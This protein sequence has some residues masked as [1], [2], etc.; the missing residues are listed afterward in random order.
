MPARSIRSFATALAAL[1]LQATANAVCIPFQ[2]AAQHI[3][4]TGCVTGKVVAISQG[5]EGAQ[6]VDFCPAHAGCGF[7]A[8]VYADDLRDVGDIRRLP[9]KT[10]EL[11]GRIRADA[12][13]PQMVLSDARQLK[14]ASP[15]LPPVPKTYDVEQRGHAAVG[16]SRPPKKPRKPKRTKPK[17]PSEGIEVPEDN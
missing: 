1:L 8:I 14:G 11:H 17:L 5:P 9:G 10:I 6:Y 13:Q 12:G 7:S 2:E 4:R 15:K 3:G 16:T